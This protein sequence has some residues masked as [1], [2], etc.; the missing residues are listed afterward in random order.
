MQNGLDHFQVYQLANEL[1]DLV[2]EDVTPLKGEPLCRPLIGQQIS[3][4]DS[5][6]ANIEEGY[7][8]DSPREYRHYLIIARGSARETRGRYRR[9]KHWLPQDLIEDRLN[10][11]DHIIGILTKVINGMNPPTKSRHP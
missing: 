1:F 11:C 6:P 7:G 3:S 5:I 9:M 10:R 2:V 8:R 4:A